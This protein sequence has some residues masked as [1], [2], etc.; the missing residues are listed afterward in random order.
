MATPAASL[1]S[2]I[3]LALLAP[4][5]ASHSNLAQPRPTR[6]LVCRVGNNQPRDC[7]GPCPPM[8][9]FGG[10][11]GVNEANPAATWTRGGSQFVAWQQNNH[12]GNKNGNGPTGFTRLSLVPV[13]EMMSRDAH[14]KNAFH[15]SCW[16][17]G[18]H[19][20]PSRDD[21]ACG[22][23]K[24]GKRYGTNVKVPTCYKDG[25]YVL[26]YSWYGGGDYQDKSFFGE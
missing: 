26:G 14:E 5:A 9:S 18:Q 12:V 21:I 19:N 16:G 20:C 4:R 24:S 1:L 10:P 6:S 2:L 11:T 7:P 17:A 25:V 3:V 15:I 22:N 13:G 23:D 8:D